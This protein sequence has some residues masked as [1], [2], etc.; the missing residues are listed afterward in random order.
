LL[1]LQRSSSFLSLYLYL[2]PH[3]SHLHYLDFNFNLIF[4]TS[5]WDL[6]ILFLYINFNLISLLHS[7]I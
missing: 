1:Y 2:F 7:E 3:T 6:G 4:L 5:F